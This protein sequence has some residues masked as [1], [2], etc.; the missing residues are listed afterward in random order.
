V[1]TDSVPA[2]SDQ[3]RAELC[4][5]RTRRAAAV[6]IVAIR[7]ASASIPASGAAKQQDPSVLTSET[8]GAGARYILPP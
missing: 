1:W 6:V 5:V 4:D 3:P 7:S 8:V 2:G